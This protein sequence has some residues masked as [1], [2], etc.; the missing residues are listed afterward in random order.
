MSR[1]SSSLMWLGPQTT[2]TTV[3]RL[4]AIGRNPQITLEAKQE[5]LQPLQKPVYP[6]MPDSN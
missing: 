5:S 1:P 2:S 6:T 3:H 4:K